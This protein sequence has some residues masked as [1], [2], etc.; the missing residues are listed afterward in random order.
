MSSKMKILKQIYALTRIPTGI[1]NPQSGVNDHVPTIKIMKLIIPF[2]AFTLF[3]C[4]FKSRNESHDVR[5][6]WESPKTLQHIQKMLTHLTEVR[7][8]ACF[9]F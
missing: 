5:V 7:T 4:P 3:A 8:G 6:K 1:N 9:Y 2:W